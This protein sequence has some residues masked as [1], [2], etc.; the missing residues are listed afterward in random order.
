MAQASR[1]LER[2]SGNNDK[3][4]NNFNMKIKLTLPGA[5]KATEKRKSLTL[6]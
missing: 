5:G 6:L 1:K 3:E 2:F 4:Q